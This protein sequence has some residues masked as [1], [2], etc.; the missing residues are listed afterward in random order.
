MAAR[1]GHIEMFEYL[2]A[3][4]AD[5]NKSGSAWATTLAWARRKEH[6]EIEKT[7]LKAGAV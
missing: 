6:A 5:V 4:G 7:L 3:M 1:W 2:L